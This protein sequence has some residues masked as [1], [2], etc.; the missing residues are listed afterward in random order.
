MSDQGTARR[1]VIK[2]A[3]Y[4]T[5]LLITL[6][7]NLEFASTGSGLAAPSDRVFTGGS[8][9]TTPVEPMPGEWRTLPPDG[10]APRGSTLPHPNHPP[11]GGSDSAPSDH[12][13]P[14]SSAPPPTKNPS[15]DDAAPPPHNDPAKDG[16]G[17]RRRPGRHRRWHV[18]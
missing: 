13:T 8:G 10:A 3:V 12:P 7:A 9:Q 17:K 1:E 4:V 18:R 6:K 15:P 16:P 11:R 2:M 14:V 5:P